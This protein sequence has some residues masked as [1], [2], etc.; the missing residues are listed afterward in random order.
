MYPASIR[1]VACVAAIA[2]VFASRRVVL[3]LVVLMSAIFLP[4]AA[5]ES[6]QKFTVLDIK[7]D[8]VGT[9]DTQ[10]QAEAA[11]K[12]LPGPSYAPDIYQ[13]VREVWRQEPAADGG[14]K[15]IYWMGKKER[16]IQ[17]SSLAGIH[18]TEQ[19]AVDASIA[20]FNQGKSPP[21]PSATMTA[22]GDW[23]KV[24]G[25]EQEVKYYSYVAP[26]IRDG[27]CETREN[28]ATFIR[29]PNCVNH[30][31]WNSELN[32]CVNE[33]IVAYIK[34]VPSQCE[35]GDT[36]TGAKPA[37]QSGLVGNPCDVKS[38]E[39][40]ETET[41]FDLGWIELTR[42]YH[43]GVANTSGGFGLGWTDSHRVQL[44]I[45]SSVIGLI[46]GQRLHGPVPRGRRRIPR[47]Q[48]QWRAHRR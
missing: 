13:H 12:T 20:V 32:A 29:F 39:K 17:Y 24:T 45:T 25:T 44:A 10:E 36:G 16:V 7:G 27:V 5:Q 31:A 26:Q 43:S 8:V 41:D 3:L 33:S 18:D 19:E 4:V 48:R 14:T 30:T 23:T 9:Y 46:E 2:Q 11:I 21:C 1:V 37:T 38:G 35:G 42:S 34:T 40:F 15:I 22:N 6:D 28:V 47:H